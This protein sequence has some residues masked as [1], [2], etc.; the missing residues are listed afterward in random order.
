[1]RNFESVPKLAEYL[2][3]LDR[4]ATAYNEYFAWKRFVKFRAHPGAASICEMCIQM[5]MQAYE[6]MRPS[7]IED[8]GE[9]WNRK[10]DC[11]TVNF[12]T[13]KIKERERETNFSLRF[14]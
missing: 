9:F 11:L 14:S 8:F 5:N 4:N 13:Y 2:L 1:M 3:Y 12:G 7:V 6:P 10:K